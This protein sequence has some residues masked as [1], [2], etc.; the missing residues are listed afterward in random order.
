MFGK[1]TLGTSCA[2]LMMFLAAT[3]LSASQFGC[4]CNT[5]LNNSNQVNTPCPAVENQRIYSIAEVSAPF[6][7][8]VRLSVVTGESSNYVWVQFEGNRYV[9]GTI[10]SEIGNQRFWEIVY[11]PIHFTSHTVKVGANHAYILDDYLV[12]QIFQILLSAPFVRPANPQIASVSV[13]Q[14][15]LV[16][17]ETTTITVSTNADV[18]HVWAEV[19]GRRINARRTNASAGSVAVRLWSINIRPHESQT[20]IV[21]AVARDSKQ[22]PVSR[23]VTIRVN[24][25]VPEAIITRAYATPENII[26]GDYTTINVRTNSDTTHVWAEV[27]GR[28]VNARR[29][30]TARSFTSTVTW[31]L[32]VSPRES[33]QITVFAGTRNNDRYADTQRV[34]VNVGQESVSILGAWAEMVNDNRVQV[35]VRTNLA[36][37]WVDIT[38][39]GINGTVT[40]SAVASSTTQGNTTHG[41]R[42]WVFYHTPV[43]GWDITPIRV[44]SGN[45]RGGGSDSRVIY[46]LR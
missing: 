2:F 21:F 19:D 33:Q 25:S 36:A 4:L 30:S 10:V 35:T 13:R 16:L 29:V 6:P 7:E 42:T 26:A 40:A 38:F 12:G 45:N 20:I 46:Q 23:D 27:D 43:D 3:S 39:P 32:K 34:R 1:M 44:F 24:E 41:E 15:N 22:D 11:R 18:E 37:E 5:S 8:S 31:E 14:S 17:G 9:Q 28:R